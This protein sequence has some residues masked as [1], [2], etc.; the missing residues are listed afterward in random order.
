MS[1]LSNVWRRSPEEIA[2]R[3]AR[4]ARIQ[5]DRL[6]TWART[7]QWDRGALLRALAPAVVDP[8]LRTHLV[9]QDWTAANRSL[10]RA[11]AARPRTFVLD[12]A[13]AAALRDQVLARW[14]NAA[15]DAARCADRLLNGSY[16]C[17]GYR[18]LSFAGDSGDVDWHLDPV[19]RRR[20]PR[21]F[22]A[23]VPYLD[24]RRTG[25]HKVIWEINRHQHWLVFGR[26]LWLTRD[27][28]YGWAMVSQLEEW[29][30][31][32]PPLIGINW[33]SALELG[34]RSVSWL[35]AMH[36]LL[37]DTSE[38]V[39]GASHAPWLLDMLL[40]LDRQMR[41]IEDNL[42]YYFSPN[43]HLLGEAVALYAVGLSVPELAGSRRWVATGRRI[44]LDEIPRQ[45]HADGG[46]VE[47]SLHYH[48]YTLDFYLLALLLAERSQDSEAITRF[49]DAVTR[50]AEF[51]HTMA[52]DR[53]CFPLIGDDDGGSVWPMA[54]RPCADMRD[55]L[56]LAGVVLARPDLARWGVPEEV[57]WIGGRTAIE[58]EPFVEAYR[59]DTKA[60]QSATFS[61]TGYVVARDA[62]GG[63][64]IFDA[65]AHGF[66]N[67]GH[68]H[69]DALS[70]TLGLGGRP[71]LVDPGTA[72]Y[73]MDR[74]LRDRMRSTANHNTVTLNGRPSAVPAGPFH[75]GT[76]A[77][78]HL[79]AA[80]HNPAFDWAEAAHEGFDDHP[81]RRTIF[82][83]PAGGWLIVDEILGRG[84]A[85]QSADVHWHFDPAWVVNQQSATCL[86]A[87]HPDGLTAWIVHDGH[88]STLWRGDES[89][90]LGWV[91]PVYGT[92]LPTWSA[93]VSA[94]GAP[95]FSI[96][97]W[98]AATAGPPML[99][100]LPAECDPGGTVAVAIRIV[101]QGVQ[102]TTVLRPGEP[103]ARE[104]R[105]C[106]AGAYH[107]NGR[108]LHYG[109]SE[110]RL[111]SL[112]A[113]DATHVLAL[114]E[115]WIS[116]AA[117]EPV[118]DLYLEFPDETIDVWTS[119]PAARV[120]LQG[121]LVTS[122]RLVRVNGRELP[123]NARERTDSVIVLPS[124]CGEPRRITP[125]AALQ[126]SQ[127]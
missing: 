43:T 28:R 103:V 49:T 76:R 48:R 14:P 44:L 120:R 13:S 63:H 6:R 70:V 61:D 74:A 100:R 113:C 19:H 126:V 51:A 57:F 58:Q 119:T 83:A 86:R 62:S 115:G 4:A 72:T 15:G 101:E 1:P 40:G 117:D 5:R 118:P 50:L 123:A 21:V 23:D 3:V 92:L 89:S 78:A 104:T 12:P 67:G 114:G 112:A 87:S 110:G 68:A 9:R 42:S 33:A 124:Q 95:P 45:I 108:L 64:L 26:A 111:I 35:W 121:A 66:M 25:D 2:W 37:A 93:R 41:H 16:D 85:R 55:S 59:R 60:P 22:W 34:F 82:R 10:G 31:A 80:R 99:T 91:A 102:W 94:A 17:L 29:M 96:A 125:C 107:T 81:H 39:A 84:T 54:G 8:V 56:A 98:I 69:A 88:E 27:R 75:W 97:T 105:G 46:H 30:E 116:V 52:D 65:G 90:G 11:L 73:T 106:A 7:P 127:R 77:D 18:G 36:F 38:G 122:A 71:F 53:G 20:A 32:N 79:D 47:R 109:S 24:G